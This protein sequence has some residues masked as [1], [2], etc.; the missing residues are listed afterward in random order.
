[1]TTKN[2]FADTLDSVLRASAGTLRPA[3]TNGV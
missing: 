1:M 2:I 3:S